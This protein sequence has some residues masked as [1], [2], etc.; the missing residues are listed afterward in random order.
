[1]P[2]N[3]SHAGL[4][5]CVGVFAEDPRERGSIQSGTCADRRSSQKR[6][7]HRSLRC[8]G[9]ELVGLRNSDHSVSGGR[10][11]TPMSRALLVGAIAL[12]VVT[13]SS[14]RAQSAA[15]QWKGRMEPTNLSAEIE[16]ALRRA[17]ADWKAVL[18]F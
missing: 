14:L 7:C 6:R 12:T 13:G 8:T 1:M 15:G 11:T 17:G 2:G 16:L 18:L 5:V 3:R 9:R 4:S 10:M